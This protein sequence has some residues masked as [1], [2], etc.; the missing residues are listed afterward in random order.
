MET[1]KGLQSILALA[2]VITIGNGL[3]EAP[4]LA[5]GFVDDTDRN[6]VLG[7]DP[8][9]VCDLTDIAEVEVRTSICDF[10][11]TGGPDVCCD[12]VVGEEALLVRMEIIGDDG[13]PKLH[14]GSFF[15]GIDYGEEES[16]GGGGLS[17]S[18]KSAT[19]EPGVKGHKTQDIT[20]QAKF[21]PQT[22]QFGVTPRFKAN[23]DP[24]DRIEIL[25]IVNQIAGVVEF[26]F[27]L[28]EIVQ[29][30]S[31]VQLTASN[32]LG[33]PR[34]LVLFFWSKCQGNLVDHAPNTEDNNNPTVASEVFIFSF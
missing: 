23:A 32:L 7:L 11:C 31:T 15:A 16:I 21:G 17:L 18:I 22:S 13:L 30:A 2:V 19:T 8:F 24:N 14:E 28:Q 5:A 10:S 33:S 1:Y 26:V 6:D 20:L 25:S 34:V 4:A 3:G 27:P 12:V 9:P 29:N